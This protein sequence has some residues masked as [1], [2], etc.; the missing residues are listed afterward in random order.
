MYNTT[1]I[2][3]KKKVEK[4]PA[5][6]VAIDVFFGAGTTGKVNSY[7]RKEACIQGWNGGYLM[8]NGNKPAA[9][10]ADWHVPF[11]SLYSTLLGLCT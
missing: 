2:K 1:L 10:A 11:A 9:A 3:K 6:Q 4:C 8:Q 7:K 5:L